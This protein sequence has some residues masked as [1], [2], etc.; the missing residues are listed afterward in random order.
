M[1]REIFYTRTESR[2]PVNDWKTNDNQARPHR[3]L[4]I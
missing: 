1:G 4:D 3:S 2:V